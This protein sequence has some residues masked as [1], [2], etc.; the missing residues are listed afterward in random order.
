MSLG[1]KISLD[2]KNSLDKRFSLDNKDSR[3]TVQVRWRRNKELAGASEEP[4][5]ARAR[6]GSVSSE[7]PPNFMIFGKIIS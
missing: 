7:V 1:E 6:R 4:A 3:C 5:E 2:K